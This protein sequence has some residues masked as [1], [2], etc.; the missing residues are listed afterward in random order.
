MTDTPFYKHEDHAGNHADVFKHLLLVNVIQELQ[1]VHPEG[2]MVA[3]AHSGYGV[4]AL[5][6]QDE[7]K[8]GIGKVLQR[9]CQTAKKYE[10]PAPIRTYIQTVLETVGADGLEDFELYPGSPLLTQ[11][12]LREGMDEHRCTD[13]YMQQVE[14]LNSAAQF[15]PLDCYDPAT[16]EFLMPPDSD[17]HHVVLLDAGFVHDD[18]YAAVQALL[19]RILER[20]PYATVLVWIPFVQGHKFRWSFATRLRELAQEKAKVGRYYANIVIQK[21][22]LQGSAMLVCNPTPLLD[23]VVDPAAL[24]W[25]AHVLHQGKDEYTVEQIMKKK[26]KKPLES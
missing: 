15:Q 25:L 21:T 11:S 8:H 17:K 16:L 10:I 5:E 24:H 14:G 4:Y 26:K 18:E 23:D 1:K 7:W 13:C 20:N 2:L 9:Y 3:D 6:N 22:G 12:L 19:Q